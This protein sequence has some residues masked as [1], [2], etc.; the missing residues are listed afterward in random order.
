MR[1]LL[2]VDGF[3]TRIY[4]LSEK[5]LLLSVDEVLV[6]TGI[7]GFLVL[8]GTGSFSLG[9]AAIFFSALVVRMGNNIVS[10]ISRLR[11]E[12]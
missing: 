11:K 2:N 10:S 9:L 12:E 6:W 1:Y 4:G 7:I 8:L 3:I 5:P